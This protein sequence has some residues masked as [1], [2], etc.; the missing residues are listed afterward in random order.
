MVK[1]LSFNFLNLLQ[2]P[3]QAIQTVHAVQDCVQKFFDT[4]TETSINST[5]GVVIWE[6][7]R[8]VV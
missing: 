3:C 4:V 6:Y 2:N 7:V 5:A 8:V 1:N